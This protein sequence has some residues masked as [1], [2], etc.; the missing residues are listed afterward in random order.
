MINIDPQEV[1]NRINDVGQEWVKTN[2]VASL[3]EESF[4]CELNTVMQENL[5][6]GSKSMADAESKARA[7]QRIFDHIAEMVNARREAN[8][9]KVKY[10]A[11]KIWFDA[12]RTQASTMR[13]ELKSLPGTK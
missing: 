5:S 12:L 11:A 2:A 10:D 1:Y 13:Q 4:K 8:E 3:L 6:Q 9:N 7:D